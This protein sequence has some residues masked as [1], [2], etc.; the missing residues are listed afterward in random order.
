M[1]LAL[2]RYDGNGRRTKV[3]ADDICP[4]L[5][6]PL[7]VRFAF[8][9]QLYIV[10]ITL[11][12]CPLCLRARGF[13]PEEACILDSVVKTMFHNGVVPIKYRWDTILTPDKHAF[14]AFP[15]PLYHKAQPC[16]IA[17]VLDTVETSPTAL[18]AYLFRF[19]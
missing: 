11:A 16:V 7:L 2:A 18:E 10:A 6:L 14:I 13:A 17:L 1:C 12:V 9:D 4:C 19:G 8:Q 3:K 5:V 15:W